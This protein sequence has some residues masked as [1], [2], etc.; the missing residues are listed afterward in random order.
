LQEGKEI[1]MATIVRTPSGTWKAIIRMK[2][3]PQT[4]KTLRL[5]KDVEDWART[6]EDEMV[7]GVY[8]RRAKSDQTMVG[9]A[10]DR[11]VRE[12]T[13]TKEE[14][15][16]GP[17]I[18]RAA[19]LK[20]HLGKYSMAA[21]TREVIAEF[22]NDRLAGTDR[23]DKDGKPIP[24]AN[25]TVRLEMALLGHLFTI[26]L[27]EWGIGLPYN[28][29]L[30]VRRPAAHPGR[31]RRLS[32]EE[33][34]RLFAL[35]E[36]HSN[37]MLYWIAGIALETTMR[38]GQIIR[39]RTFQVNLKRRTVLLPKTKNREPQTI[40]LSKLATELFR[41]ALGHP[42]RPKE[43]DLIFFGEPGRDGTRRP[44]QFLSIWRNIKIE[45]GL[46]DVRFHDL[47]HEAISRL[48][49]AGFTD[50]EAASISG[51]KSMQ[52]LKR[53]THLR[54]ENFVDRLDEM[55][56]KRMDSLKPRKKAKPARRSK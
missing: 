49:E 21:L 25:D 18:R 8:V 4:I 43:T 31:S 7:R 29:V 47:R 17:E 9:D 26:A 55:R 12:I 37:P 36:K 19:I 15:T 50:Q 30:S 27:E 13:P 22:R 53:Y 48:I 10:I 51:H 54:N 16:R 38:E 5:K 35:I 1:D 6:T 45:A 52:M 24:R 2:G 34:E 33:E 28:P 46:L 39:L 32:I 56:L 41:L 23:K 3:W 44:Y 40:P 14:S 20:R 11:Y 42:T